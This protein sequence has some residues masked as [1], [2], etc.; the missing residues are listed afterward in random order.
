[1]HLLVGR[2]A[3][4]IGFDSGADWIRTRAGGVANFVES[5]A[6]L[7]Q[8]GTISLGG[9]FGFGLDFGFGTLGYDH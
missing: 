6:T 9:F 1:L 3:N 7:A 2:D 4:P 8:T 5:L